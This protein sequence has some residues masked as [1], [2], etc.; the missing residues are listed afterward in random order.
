MTHSLAMTQALK[1][2]KADALQ[3]AE[4][5]SSA[6]PARKATPVGPEPVDYADKT[7][8]VVD[9]G[10]FCEFATTLAKQFGKTYLYIPW[11]STFPTRWQLL[12]GQGLEGVE[13]VE[14]LWDVLDEVDLFVFPDQHM[15]PLQEYLVSIGKRVWGSRRGE[16]LEQDR[17]ASKEMLIEAGCDVGPYEVVVGLKALRE[18]LKKNKNQYVK[19]SRTRG[20]FETF[21]SEEYKTVEPRLDELEYKLGPE[22]EHVRFVVEEAI[23]EAVEVAYDGY[24]IDGQYPARAMVGIEV[25]DR[26]YLGV[27]Q[28][29]DEMPQQIQDVNAK[30]APLLKQYHYR[31][32]WAAESR[33]TKDGTPWVID[34]CC[35]AGSPPSELLQMAYTN[36]ADIFWH[37]AEG[38]CVD[39]IPADTWGAEVIITSSRGAGNFLS[40]WETIDFPEE[41]RANV[42]LRFPMKLDG[43]FYM[44]IVDKVPILGAV[45]ATGPT[46]D[47]CIKN[48]AKVAEQVGGYYVE[49]DVDAL[50][51]ADEELAKL[52][53]FGITLDA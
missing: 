35:R 11:E 46:K 50:Q 4:D 27:M 26:G 45:R 22:K 8:L 44:S 34:P 47:Q 48:L 37:G 25:K 49:C 14:S 13:K 36:L 39:P 28:E 19:V 21:K 43:R 7:V 31:N 5:R 24:T 52:K 51:A 2:K 10:L 33:I 15:G 12:I 16:I 3:R 38:V 41:V 17:E 23:P 29:Y 6:V 42:C 30:C 40:K 9:F 18:F 20:D 32:F 1:K 53:K